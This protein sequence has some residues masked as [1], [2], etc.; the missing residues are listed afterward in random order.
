M[1]YVSR[2]DAIFTD[3]VEDCFYKVKT[4]HRVY[5]WELKAF[6]LGNYHRSRILAVAMGQGIRNT[7]DGL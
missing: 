7:I 4:N 3:F 1:S 6:Y 2:R 5:F